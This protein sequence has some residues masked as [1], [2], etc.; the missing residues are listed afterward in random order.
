[1]IITC[2]NCATRYT[3]NAAS[4]PATGRTVKCARC[5]QTW[6]ALPADEAEIDL[7]TPDAVESP[8]NDDDPPDTDPPAMETSG[9][10]SQP[11]AAPSADDIPV[12]DTGEPAEVEAISDDDGEIMAF[13]PADDMAQGD[14]NV[15]TGSDAETVFDPDEPQTIDPA[16]TDLD[17]TDVAEDEDAVKAEAADIDDD[18]VSDGDVGDDDRQRDAAA[19]VDDDDDIAGAPAPSGA[20]TE[21]A[22][23]ARHAA[24]RFVQRKSSGAAPASMAHR[25]KAM[26]VGGMVAGLVAG[27]IYREDVVRSVPSLAGLYGLVGYEINLRG[28]AFEDVTPVQEMT[29]GIPVL[30]IAGAIRN[31][32]DTALS[33]PP[34]RLSLTS[35][36]GQEIYFWTI[37][38]AVEV[39]EAGQSAK[40]NSVLSAPPRAAAGVAVRFVNPDGVR[41]GLAQ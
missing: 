24:R 10:V 13:E 19:I 23:R 14:E 40:F 26:A 15:E 33:V 39:L 28:L 37:K 35:L 30:R 8:V 9:A 11:V 32:T 34:V 3:V 41:I 6:Y 17:F 2:P 12:A 7:E 25:I 1:M 20:P 31:V 27:I 16:D 29:Q 22:A 5:A 4:F 18:D 21:L 38:P 36:S